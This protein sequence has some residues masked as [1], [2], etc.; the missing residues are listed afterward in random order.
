[1]YPRVSS[2]NANMA[3]IG[4]SIGKVKKRVGDTTL[5]HCLVGL[6]RCQEMIC[7]LKRA[8]KKRLLLQLRQMKIQRMCLGIGEPYWQLQERNIKKHQVN[9]SQL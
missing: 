6:S 1:M 7:A 4:S 5:L 8:R 3:E 2:V 9:I